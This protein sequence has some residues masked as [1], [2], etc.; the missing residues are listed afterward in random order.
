MLASNILS[1]SDFLK[2][3][4]EPMQIR[5]AIVKRYKEIKNITQVAKEFHTSKASVVGEVTKKQ[6]DL[7]RKLGVDVLS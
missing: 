2:D 5:L 7:Y 4:P 1:Y 3:T 6:N